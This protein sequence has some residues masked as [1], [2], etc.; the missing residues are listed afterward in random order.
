MLH[1]AAE[2][3]IDAT[4]FYLALYDPATQTVEVVRQIDSGCELPGGTFPLGDGF[5]SH[6]IRTG[7]PLLVRHWSAE[8]A[9]IA[10]QAATGRPGLPES[11]ITVPL[12]SSLEGPPLG[13]LTIQS[14]RVCAYDDADLAFM[15]ALAAETARFIEARDRA[16]RAET[17]A[18]RKSRELEGILSSIQDA[19]IVTDPAGA[20]IRFNTAARDLFGPAASIVVGQ[21]LDQQQWG[22]WPLGSQ[23]LAQ[24]F[25]PLIDDL[26]HGRARKDLE[27]QLEGRLDRRIVSVNLSPIFDCDGATAGGILLMHDV[28]A[29]RALE[30]LKDNLLS[31][32]RSPRAYWTHVYQPLAPRP[33]WSPW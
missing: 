14:Y 15:T 17:R 25:R 9:P 13:V 6:V 4:G 28:T 3:V 24:A 5:T 21:P 27:V 22:V 18:L 26:R 23:R 19:L 12:P 16:R 2:P 29:R 7:Q 10:I 20:I 1:R 30:Q 32:Q 31:T 8:R 11:G 33:D